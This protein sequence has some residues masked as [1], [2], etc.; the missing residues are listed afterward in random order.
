MM[1]IMLHKNKPWNLLD[2]LS[3]SLDRFWESPW[4]RSNI[5]KKETDFSPACDFHETDTHYFFSLDIPGVKKEN[6]NVEYDNNILHISGEKKNEYKSKLPSKSQF[7]ERYCGKFYRS[8]K[9]PVSVKA[10]AI[11]ASFKNGVLELLLPK[12]TTGKG[13]KISIG[14]E[15]KD[16]LLSRLT[17]ASH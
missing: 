7:Y 17:K 14:E 1:N 3:S 9:L 11:E 12:Q 5:V 15:K 8:F 10:D 2:D 16:S 13:R 4:D 6:I